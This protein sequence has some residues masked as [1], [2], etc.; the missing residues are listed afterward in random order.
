MAIMVN[1]ILA[2]RW[3]ANHFDREFNW[4]CIY[5]P[6]PLHMLATY[7]IGYMSYIRT[8]KKPYSYT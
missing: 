8:S 5:T 4:T 2:L 6:Y 3:D 7:V 1:K